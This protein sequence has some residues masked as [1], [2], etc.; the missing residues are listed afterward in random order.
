MTPIS[1]YRISVP[2]ASSLGQAGQ[3]RLSWLIRG[4]SAQGRQGGPAVVAAIVL[5][6]AAIA[7]LNYL[8]PFLK[9]PGA[10]TVKECCDRVGRGTI[11]T[12][13]RT[14]SGAAGT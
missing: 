4:D 11:V 3:G 12:S 10:E 5:G 7:F 6:A 1:A 9:R 13:S 8:F 14:S 2:P